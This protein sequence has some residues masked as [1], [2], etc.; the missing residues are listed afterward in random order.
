VFNDAKVDSQQ[1][2]GMEKEAL[3]FYLLPDL[4]V[5]AWHLKA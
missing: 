3:I 2:P 5:K 4:K 1:N